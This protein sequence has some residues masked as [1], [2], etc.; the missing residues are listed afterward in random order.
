MELWGRQEGDEMRDGRAYS[1]S[2]AVGA[3][4]YKMVCC[5]WDS[6]VIGKKV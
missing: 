2:D 4:I 6:D 5:I 3:H 1:E